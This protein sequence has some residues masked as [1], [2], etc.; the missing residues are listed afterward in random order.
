MQTFFVKYKVKDNSKQSIH[1]WVDFLNT[2]QEQVLESLRDEGVAF[3]FAA[4]DEQVDGLYLI[5]AMK[6]KNINKV[7]ESLE[8]SVREVDIFQ[9]ETL[10]L[11]LEKPKELNVVVDFENPNFLGGEFNK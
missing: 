7:F 6:A 5:Y 8:D 11:I 9:K 2:H 4:L 3:E 1:T 10:P